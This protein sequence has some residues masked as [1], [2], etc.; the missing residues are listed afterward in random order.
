VPPIRK[1]VFAWATAHSGQDYE[2][3]SA[4]RKAALFGDLHGNVLEIGPGAGANLR[5]YPP[6]IHWLGVEPN[7]YMHCYLLQSIHALGLLAQNF[8]IDP[9]DRSGSRLPA[10]DE[11]VDA[12]VSTLVLCSVANPA[13][14]M[15]EI[16]RVLKP[17]GRFAFI[18]HVAA[19]QGSRLR[20]WQ[21]R[22][23]PL[24]TPLADGCHPNRETWTTISHAGFAH[25]DIEHYH[26]LGSS[27]AAPHIAGT[28]IK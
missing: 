7:P 13:A 14:T 24:W 10:A 11:S 21:D 12:V 25:V 9:G 16:L 6:H 28:A 27:L 3:S 18:E 5:Y 20:T 2:P 1:R 22:L 15:Q 4:E 23:Q 19:E 8:R 17:G 26:S